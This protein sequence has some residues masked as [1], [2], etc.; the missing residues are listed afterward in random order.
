MIC[1]R[2]KKSK[3]PV[4]FLVRSNLRLFGDLGGD[5]WNIVLDL[6]SWRLCERSERD[7]ADLTRWRK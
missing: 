1:S 2:L 3:K 7:L 5:P 6:R 4:S